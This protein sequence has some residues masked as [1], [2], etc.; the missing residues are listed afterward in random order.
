MATY[1]FEAKIIGRASG[2]SSVHTA[3]HNTGKSAMRAV[4]YRMRESLHD[5]RTGQTHDYSR[6]FGGNGSDLYIP[7]NAPPWM[8]H[9]QT[10]WNAVERAETRSNAQLARD[11]VITLPYALNHEQHRALIR[12]FVTLHFL[13]RGKVA[14]VGYHAYGEPISAKSPILP[15]KMEKWRKERVVFYERDQ[16]PKDFNTRHVV[17]LRHRDGSPKDYVRYQPHAHVMVPLRTVDA[18]RETGFARLKDRPPDGTNPMK[19]WKQDL[20]NLRRG[21]ADVL[22]QHFAAAGID[23]RVDHRSLNDR[24]IDRKPEPKKGP[25]AAKMEREGRGDD[26]NAIID[27]FKVHATNAVIRDI[28]TQIHNLNLERL[29]LIKSGVQPMELTPGQSERRENEV[30]AGLS[31][32]DRDTQKVSD[33][34][35][36]HARQMATAQE[37]KKLKDRDAWRNPADEEI[38]DARARWSQACDVYGNMRD[39]GSLM[40]SAARAEG[41]Q[42]RK[43]QEEL[44]QAEARESDPAKREIIQIHRHVE[45]S[46]YMA[47]TSE[48]L[49][50]ISKFL[51][52]HSGS[53]SEEYYKA[54]AGKYREIA[55]AEREKLSELR[56]LMDKQN[57]DK[58]HEGL[59]EMDSQ[60][61][62]DPFL[63]RMNRPSPVPEKEQSFGVP[64][65]LPDNAPNRDRPQNDQREPPAYEPARENPYEPAARRDQERWDAG[66]E[67]TDAQKERPEPELSDAQKERLAMLGQRWNAEE[68][69]ISAQQDRGR[70]GGMSR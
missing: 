68:R 57:L 11:F 70:G 66:K 59:K 14:D 21:W 50:G 32:I 7:E 60:E 13:S 46:D 25:V 3:S 38:T 27:V 62:A 53:E 55:A 41:A 40:A 12:D 67:K 61:R 31:H 30:S 34:W 44:R 54:E 69:E 52:G 19:F 10:L 18:M 65:D 28:D 48:R 22:N 9:R 29:D 49:A 2:R 17:I 37:D 35:Q 16:I 42:F 51:S 8:A 23:E 63:R 24:G 6:K 39:P 33:W 20:G 4:A 58:L 26:A 56:E 15:E 43:E 5:E 64:Q 47:L 1:R 36:E 45:A